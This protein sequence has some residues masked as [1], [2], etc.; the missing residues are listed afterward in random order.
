M[1]S[2]PDVFSIDSLRHAP[3]QTTC[4]DGVRNYQARNF[5]Q[6]EIK[7]GDG[8]LFYH[9]NAQPIGIA[10]EAVVVREGYPDHTAFDPED[11]HYDPKSTPDR[12]IWYMVDVR[13]VRACRTMITLARL[14]SI[15]ALNRMAVVRRGMR[16]SV[17]PVRPDEWNTIMALPEWE[18]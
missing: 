10:G 15:P 6:H 16:L 2:E 7:V 3:G 13:Y 14:R 9:S 4:W 5:L 17:Q 11:I 12:P 8:V 1:K 18:K